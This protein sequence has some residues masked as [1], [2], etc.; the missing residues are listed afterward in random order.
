MIYHF[1]RIFRICLTTFRASSEHA[2]RFKNRQKG[3]FPLN[4][5]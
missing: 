4:I 5:A 2:K 3:I 1:W